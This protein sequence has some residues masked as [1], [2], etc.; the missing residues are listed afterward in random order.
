MEG[1]YSTSMPISTCIQFIIHTFL[2]ACIISTGLMP[3]L[4]ED[5]SSIKAPVTRAKSPNMMSESLGLFIP[6][7]SAPADL[8]ILMASSC[9]AARFSTWLGNFSSL[10]YSALI[11][12]SASF[13]FCLFIDLSMGSPSS[14]IDTGV[15]HQVFSY[16]SLKDSTHSSTQRAS[17]LP[18]LLPSRTFSLTSSYTFIFLPPYHYR[19]YGRGCC[20]SRRVV[21]YYPIAPYFTGMLKIVPLSPDTYWGILPSHFSIAFN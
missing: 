15:F 20:T 1:V 19:Q 3:G 7:I 17:F 11:H 14:G 4:K 13:S 6:K 5:A 9:Q 12:I 2:M 8:A 16:L 10:P 18:V 21:R